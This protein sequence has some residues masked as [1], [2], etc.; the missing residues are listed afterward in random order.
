MK[1]HLIKIIYLALSGAMAPTTACATS[2]ISTLTNPWSAGYAVGGTHTTLAQQFTTGVES[3][4]IGSVTFFG[5]LPDPLQIA[6]YSDAAGM[7]DSLLSNGMLEWTSTVDLTNIYSAT[8][9]TLAANTTYWLE[10]INSGPQYDN[11]QD[12]YSFSSTGSSGWTLG[13]AAYN[14]GSGLQAGFPM[15]PLF[16]INSPVPE[17]STVALSAM[18]GMALLRLR[19]RR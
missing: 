19:R 10:F 3:L 18:G 5:T 11:I 9:L 17:A 12:S 16:A 6:F 8:N 4:P 1:N 14:A 7:P 15:A 13:V 2:Y